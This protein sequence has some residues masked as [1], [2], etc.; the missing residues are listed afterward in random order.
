MARLTVSLGQAAGLVS[1]GQPEDAGQKYRLRPFL[2]LFRN[3]YL[4]PENKQTKPQILAFT[5]LT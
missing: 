5:T 3:P 2:C 1:P 4:F